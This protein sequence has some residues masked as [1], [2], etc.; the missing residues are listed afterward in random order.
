MKT[1]FAAAIMTCC[2]LAASAQND[3]TLLGMSELHVNYQVAQLCDYPNQWRQDD[4]RD[5][6]TY[7]L[8]QPCTVSGFLIAAGGYKT[9]VLEDAFDI[10]VSEDGEKWTTAWSGTN[11]LADRRYVGADYGADP[12]DGGNNPVTAILTDSFP[13]VSIVR[14][15][16]YAC[17][18]PRAVN[19][20]YIMRMTEFD[21]LCAPDAD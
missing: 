8:D 12:V 13:A 1:L 6:L 5:T 19:G 2:T 11:L 10:L 14:Y 17:V 7:E 20:H 4:W 16:A 3:S 9:G 15:V 21:V 18:T